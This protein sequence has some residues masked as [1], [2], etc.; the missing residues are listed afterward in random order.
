M[1]GSKS[2]NNLLKNQHQMSGNRDSEN[3]KPIIKTFR[4]CIL[5]QG[6]MFGEEDI[7]ENRPYSLTVKCISTQADVFCIKEDEFIRRL[8]ANKESWKTILAMAEEK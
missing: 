8:K 4:V 2:V 3:A 6:Q 5:G 1:E 7:I